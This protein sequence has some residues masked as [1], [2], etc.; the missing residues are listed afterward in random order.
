[1]GDFYFPYMPSSPLIFP[2]SSHE[3]NDSTNQNISASSG[4]EAS[5]SQNIFTA[6]SHA[7]NV[8]FTENQSIPLGFGA[9]PSLEVLSLTKLSSN[10]EQQLIDSSWDYCD[11]EIVVEGLPVPIHRFILAARS[12]F[13]HELFKKEKGP[14][15]KEEK[16]R[17]LMSDLLPHGRVGYEA[18]QVVLNYLYAGKLKP[19][20]I[21]SRLVNFVNKAYVEDV[22]PILLVAFHCQASQLV[23]QCVNRIVRSDLDSILIE[24][25]LPYQVSEE[26]KFLRKELTSDDEQKMEVVDPLR[27]MR[28]RRIYKALDLDDI[29]QV[30]LVLA[31]SDVTL[32]DAN[33]LHYAVA[34]CSPKIVD[35][36]LSLGLAN[37]NLRNS[38]GYTVLHI[39]A[40]QREP[41][42]IMSLLAK[43]ACASDLTLEGRSAVSICR[44]LTRP[45]DWHAKTVQGQE[46]SKFRLCI[47]VLERERQRN[48]TSTDVS[49]TSLTL[50]DDL[51]RKLLYLENRVA[52]ARLL[53]PVEAKVTRDI[54]H[55]DENLKELDLN[56]TPTAQK[57]RL[58][59]RLEALAKTVGLARRFFPTCYE[60]LDKF[61]DHLPDL[62]YL[63]R[64]SP[65]EQSLR[66][67]RFLEL[68]ED[69]MKAFNKDR[70]E[71]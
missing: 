41:S 33:A 27:E 35:E 18:L 53:F 26:I 36:V 49:I 7:S 47:D 1:M 22:I 16:P 28:I 20:P 57:K 63:E 29:E 23:A 38:Q 70:A 37:V 13:F 39:A 32:D 71:F 48:P 46:A 19:S 25:D 9:S 11:A 60:V 34:Y 65:E 4:S 5:S 6:S 21:E 2:S 67:R 17:Y 15:D 62:F 50:F 3:S 10:L 14:L 30:K 55:A 69:L 44:R 58:V 43:G 40:L 56:E 31:D 24:K 52:L 45:K 59:S 61:L 12:R 64:G 54:A 51:H 68:K 66:R 8:L 42:V